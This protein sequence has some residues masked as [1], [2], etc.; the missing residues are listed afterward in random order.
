MS[1]KLSKTNKYSNV[2]I[3]FFTEIAQDFKSE[4]EYLLN[5]IKY[6]LQKSFTLK[7]HY[8]ECINKIK[9]L[10]QELKFIKER[11]ES[12]I[13]L[14]NIVTNIFTFNKNEKINKNYNSEIKELYL[15]YVHRD[16]EELIYFDYY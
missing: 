10:S 14:C 1:Q 12:K 13:F 11:K 4:A 15:K 9:V 2:N 3:D 8:N 6:G 7:D 5:D 16:I